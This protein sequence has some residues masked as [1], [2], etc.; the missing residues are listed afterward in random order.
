VCFAEAMI[1]FE[2]LELEKV[3]FL[4]CIDNVD[5]RWKGGVKKTKRRMC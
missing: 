3:V 5:G 2:V 1:A 4:E